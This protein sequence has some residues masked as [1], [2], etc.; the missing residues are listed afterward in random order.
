[1]SKKLNLALLS[2]ILAAALLFFQNCGQKFASQI[3]GPTGLNAICKAQNYKTSPFSSQKLQMNPQILSSHLQKLDTIQSK[4]LSLVVNPQCLSSREIEP[5]FLGQI[6]EVDTHFKKLTRVAIALSLPSLP[7]PDVLSQALENNPCVIGLAENKL[8]NVGQT[9][10]SNDPQIGKQG[11]LQFLGYQDSLTLQKQITSP[12]VVAVIDTGVDYNHP[13]LRNRMWQGPQGQR[14]FNFINGTSNPMDDDGH[15]THVAGI[16]AAE[17][18]NANGGAGLTLGFARIMAI[19]S[20][21]SDGSGSSQNVYNGIMYAINNGADIINLSVEAPGQNTLLEDALNEAVNA[22]V[23]VVASTGNQAAEILPTNLFAPAYIAPQFEGVISVASVDSFDARLSFYS[24]YSPI[25]AELSAPGA[26]ISANFERG[27][28]STSPNN[29]FTR[30]MGTSQSSPMVTA[31][32]AILIGYLKTQGVS[33]TPSGVENFLGS[34]GSGMR[35]QLEPYIKGG[36]V[37]HIGFLSSN[38]IQ[39]FENLR[40]GDTTFDDDASTGNQCVIN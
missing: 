4:E 18:N 27:I 7:S 28:L 25:Y 10:I 6:L 36:R 26:E 35:P 29:R 34:D 1:M 15:G 9:A 2:A 30:I 37:L 11:H 31:A 22:G 23:V 38:L 19:K 20:L 13:D 40:N 39:Y 12:V 24:N 17:E 16:I 33:Y 5:D 8:V 21:S 14:G 3:A 32:A